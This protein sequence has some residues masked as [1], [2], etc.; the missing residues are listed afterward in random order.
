MRRG[1]A[2]GTYLK[3]WGAA[4]T[5]ARRQAARV[6]LPGPSLASS[7]QPSVGRSEQLTVGRALR[8][9]EQESEKDQQGSLGTV[10][11]R[12]ALACVGQRVNNPRVCRISA[13]SAEKSTRLVQPRA[14]ER[15]KSAN[16]PP[17]SNTRA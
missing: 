11:H 7:T 9:A 5:A 1:V 8:G 3:L 16:F 14:Y 12:V 2:G 13:K 15:E 4:S 6:G 10:Q 17:A